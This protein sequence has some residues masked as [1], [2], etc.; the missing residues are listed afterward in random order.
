MS[1]DWEQDT[2]ES[3]RQRANGPT[4]QFVTTNRDLGVMTRVHVTNPSDL[5][6]L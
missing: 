6:G 3:N 5:T 2:E 1:S 4:L